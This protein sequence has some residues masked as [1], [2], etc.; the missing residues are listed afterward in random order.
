MKTKIDIILE[1]IK[2]LKLKLIKVQDYINASALRSMEREYLE[3]K[4]NLDK[5]L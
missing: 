5:K 4:N 2:S 1:E 3:I